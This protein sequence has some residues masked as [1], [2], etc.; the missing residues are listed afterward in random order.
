MDASGK[1]EDFADSGKGQ[2]KSH[3][4]NSPLRRLLLT[5]AAPLKRQNFKN[6]YFK[7]IRT[8]AFNRILGNKKG[9]RKNSDAKPLPYLSGQNH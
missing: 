1:S 4:H 8:F 2:K 3:N 7:T 9:N 5:F 6:Q